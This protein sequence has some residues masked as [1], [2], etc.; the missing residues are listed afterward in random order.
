MLD[1]KFNSNYTIAVD[2]VVK[3]ISGKARGQK[4]LFKQA[5]EYFEKEP[6][7]RAKLQDLN[8]QVA[9]LQA[10]L[11]ATPLFKFKPK[12]KLLELEKLEKELEKEKSLQNK[13]RLIR[14]HNAIDVCLRLLSLT[15]GGEFDETQL[16]SSKYLATIL[17]FSPGEGKRLAELHQ[18]LKPSYRAVLSL[19][20]L[21]K[22]LAGKGLKNT[23]ILGHYDAQTRYEIGKPDN[24]NFTQSIALPIMFAAIFQEIGLLHP[25]VSAILEGLEGNLDRYRTLDKA[26]RTQVAKFTNQYTLEYLEQGLGLQ[27]DIV[28][29]TQDVKAFKEAEEKR[30]QFQLTLV[31]DA[32]STKSGT[33]EIIRIPQIYTSIIFPT[34]REF[35]KS[36]LP[37]ASVLIAQL[38]SKKKISTQVANAFISIVGKFPMGYGVVY[39]PR[40]AR[41]IELNHYEYALVVGLNPAKVDE[42]N[43]RLVSRNLLFSEYGKNEVIEASRNMHYE[44]ARKKLERIDPKKLLEI[45]QTLTHKFDP[46]KAQQLIPLYWEGYNYFIVEGYQNLWNQVMRE[47]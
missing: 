9:T 31:K 2:T 32:N 5:E 11:D 34:K 4:S 16:K 24:V 47:D 8:D 36:T 28:G 7:N 30:I 45:R 44:K 40:D 6:E 21:D 10:E 12:I 43:C 3:A 22:L 27:Q 13:A 37:N 35:S 38:A 18:S 1:K 46:K 41:G 33:S 15:E 20:L 17:L 42:P 14:L 29:S 26:E 23:H 25:K 19:R 39:L